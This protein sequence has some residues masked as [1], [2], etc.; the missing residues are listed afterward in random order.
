MDEKLFNDSQRTRS[1]RYRTED[2]IQNLRI[3][4]I[5]QVSDPD[6]NAARLSGGSTS[7]ERTFSWQDKVFGPSEYDHYMW[8]LDKEAKEADKNG[9]TTKGDR[10]KEERKKEEQEE[11][12]KNL[13]EAEVQAAK[14]EVCA[15][16]S[17]TML[18]NLCPDTA[19]YVFCHC[20]I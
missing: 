16:P 5:L 3:K 17:P 7:K 15:V 19:M 8:L 4:V 18:L 6:D 10:E 2:A 20:C 13:S 9:N 12:D 14:A 11:E 1:V